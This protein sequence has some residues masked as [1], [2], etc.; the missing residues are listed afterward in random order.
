M[1]AAVVTVCAEAL[2]RAKFVK[3]GRVADLVVKNSRG[4]ANI[5]E[6]FYLPAEWT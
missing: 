1:V 4:S 5:V 3:G 2:V 6:T